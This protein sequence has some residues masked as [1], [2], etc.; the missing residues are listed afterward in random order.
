MMMREFVSLRNHIGVTVLY[1]AREQSCFF[2]HLFSILTF[3][4]EIKDN[5]SD[6]QNI[7]FGICFFFT[8]P[9]DIEFR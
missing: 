3:R 8:S 2:C 6:K 9:D 1:V 5:P 7:C 4:L